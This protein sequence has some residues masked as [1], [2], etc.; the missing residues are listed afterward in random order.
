MAKIHNGL[1]LAAALVAGIGVLGVSAWQSGQ[2]SQREANIFASLSE[3]AFDQGFCDRALRVAI[4][5]LPPSTGASPFSFSSPQLLG[6]LSFF[7]SNPDCYFQVALDGHKHLVSS[8]AFSADGSRV[9]TTSWDGTVRLWDSETGAGLISLVGHTGWINGAAFSPDGTRIVTASWDKTAG[10]GRKNRRCSCDPLRPHCSGERRVVQPRR[11]ADRDR[12]Q[13]RHGASLG[14]P[15]RATARD[16]LRTHR[17]GDHGRI[18]FGRSRILTASFD[19]TARLW[20]GSSGA[21][22]AT[23]SGHTA[24]LWRARFS[25]DGA[26]VVTASDDGTAR[27]WDA[28]TGAAGA[29]AQRPWRSGARRGVQPGWRF[30]RDRVRR[31]HR[32]G[33]ECRDRHFTDDTF[34]TRRLG[35]DRGVQS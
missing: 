9:L 30:G 29:G 21:I 26:H 20:D 25:P 10:V 6:A 28:E 4:A 32:G 8:A 24:L 15:D 17:H 35:L 31:R 23:L 11:R 18:K 5:G 12:V 1:W 27:L 2:T 22:L 7:G 13:R 34:R 16:P 14:R 19:G 3:T 33:M